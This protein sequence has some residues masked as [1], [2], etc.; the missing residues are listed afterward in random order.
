MI[1]KLYEDC[2]PVNGYKRS[3]IFDATRATFRTI[4][5][6]LYNF[7]IEFDKTSIDVISKNFSD[8]ENLIVD[9]YLMFLLENEYIFEVDNELL[10][11]F[12]KINLD[13]DY[14]SKIN[15][16]IICFSPYKWKL[17]VTKIIDLLDKLNCQDIQIRFCEK[18]DEIELFDLLDNFTDSKVNSMTLILPYFKISKLFYN[19]LIKNQW[20]DQVVFFNATE[21]IADEDLDYSSNQISYSTKSISELFILENSNQFVIDLM[22]FCESQLHHSYYNRK[23]FIDEFGQIKNAPESIEIFGNIDDINDFNLILKNEA[24]QKYWKLTK[25][26][27]DVCKVCEFRYICVDNRLP[28]IRND[29]SHYHQTECNYNPYICKWFGENGYVNLAETG[30]TC[31]EQGLTEDLNKIRQVN[32]TLS[33]IE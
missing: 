32:E 30:I 18:I 1:I 19:M 24:F 28:I 25:D 31:D 15:N 10:N 11:Q 20:I 8:K 21:K 33:K 14:P 6:S 17:R 29:G 5:N 22:L 26:K 9:E 3:L 13:W 4:P 12:P 16:A 23:L 27:C 2:I 7:L